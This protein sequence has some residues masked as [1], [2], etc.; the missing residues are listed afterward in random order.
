MLG[1][2]RPQ[3]AS[4]SAAKRHIRPHLAP[5]GDRPYVP[6][7]QRV[8][9]SNPARRTNRPGQSHVP[10]LKDRAGSPTG[11]HRNSF[12]LYRP[13]LPHG[14]RDRPR[15]AAKRHDGPVITARL[16]AC[17]AIQSA[18][19][20]MKVKQNSCSAYSLGCGRTGGFG[21]G[22]EEGIGLYGDDRRSACTVR[23]RWFS[24]RPAA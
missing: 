7:K 10:I 16:P 6:S 13:F 14:E 21:R 22:P 24:C 11:S 4:I 19:D 2:T 12:P 20:A 1:Y 9:G 8:A 18:A 23:H 3:S 5:S 17:A 15:S